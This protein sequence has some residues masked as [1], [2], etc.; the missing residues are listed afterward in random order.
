MGSTHLSTEGGAPSAWKESNVSYKTIWIR[1]Q[2]K[3]PS[4]ILITLYQYDCVWGLCLYNCIL[5]FCKTTFFPPR[6][7]GVIHNFVLVKYIFSPG[8]IWWQP[9]VWENKM[10][11]FKVS[12]V[13]EASLHALHSVYVAHEHI[14][15]HKLHFWCIVRVNPCLLAFRDWR[16]QVLY[17]G[18]CHQLEIR[19]HLYNVL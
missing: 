14:T 2:C 12:S 8:R 3:H 10:A 6:H 4:A 1:S 16:I 18:T 11:A 15:C 5:L 7:I 9:R 19:C 17:C 13:T